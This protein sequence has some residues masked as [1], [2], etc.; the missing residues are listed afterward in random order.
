LIRAVRVSEDEFTG[1]GPV[2]VIATG[3]VLAAG[4][5]RLL[6]RRD[7]RTPFRV[8]FVAT[9]LVAVM[10]FAACLR[11]FPV[12]TNGLLEG[13]FSPF[14]FLIDWLPTAYR[15]GRGG[16]LDDGTLA[17]RLFLYNCIVVA[18]LLAVPQLAVAVAGGLIARQIARRRARP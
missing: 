10:T 3:N 11:S 4:L 18:A 14:R 12:G 2:Y 6:V 17:A 16:F 1:V 15:R 5:I 13:F 9:G 7:S 8:G